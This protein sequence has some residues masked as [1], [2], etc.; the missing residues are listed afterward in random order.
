MVR[1]Y[2]PEIDSMTMISRPKKA[3]TANRPAPMPPALTLN[4]SSLLA[5]LISDCTSAEMSRLASATSRP[6]VGSSALFIPASLQVTH[7][8]AQ[9]SVRPVP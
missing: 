8:I 1:K 6:M 7:R 5:S 9:V 4:F 2:A 3:A